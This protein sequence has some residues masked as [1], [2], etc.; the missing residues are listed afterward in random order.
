MKR[1]ELPE[2]C[3]IDFGSIATELIPTAP[4]FE[5]LWDRHPNEYSKIMIHGRTV[6]VPR[7]DQAFE[8]DYPFANQVAKALPA[9]KSMMTFLNLAQEY[10][11]KRLNGLFVN[12]HDGA[13]SHYHGKHRDSTIGLIQG[14]PIVTLS[15]GEERVFRLRPYPDRKPLRDFLM[16]NGDAIVIPWITNQKWTHEIPNFVRYQ[17]RRISITMR[18]FA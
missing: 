2:G 6:K 3:H 18:A 13:K 10:V 17:E 15:L 16:H 14:T 9:P 11:D 4:G 1:I 12:W 5:L 7:W 8:R